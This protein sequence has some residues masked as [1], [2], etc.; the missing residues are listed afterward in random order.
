MIKRKIKRRRPVRNRKMVE[1][2]E[3]PLGVGACLGFGN[4]PKEICKKVLIFHKAHAI[5]KLR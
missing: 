3:E 2:H 5:M 1:E 4:F